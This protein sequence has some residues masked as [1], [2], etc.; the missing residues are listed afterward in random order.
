MWPAFMLAG[1]FADSLFEN[2]VPRG[3][4]VRLA[5]AAVLFVMLCL[6]FFGAASSVKIAAMAFEKLEKI[7]SGNSSVST[8]AAYVAAQSGPGESVQIVSYSQAAIELLAGR[9]SKY[10]MPS[11]AETVLK[12]QHEKIREAVCVRDVNK[13]FIDTYIGQ[14]NPEYNAAII[15]AARQCGTLKGCSGDMC[16]Y[17]KQP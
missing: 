2:G 5:R 11:L 17:V 14:M 1:I 4:A 15:K 10:L 7:H 12:S 3:G 9:K 6:M 8:H 13:V 16:L